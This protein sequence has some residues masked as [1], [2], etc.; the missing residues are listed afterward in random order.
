MNMTELKDLVPL[1][2]GVKTA[3]AERFNKTDQKLTGM[4][5]ELLELQQKAAG[6]SSY[7]GGGDF[8]GRNDGAIKQLFDAE[9]EG[10]RRDR[11]KTVAF[12]LPK[13]F[14][15]KTAII[16]ATGQNQPLVVAQRAPMVQPVQRRLSIRDLIPTFRTPSNLIEFTRE[17]AFTNNAAIVYASPNYENVTKPESAVTFSLATA[18]VQTLAHW[19][20]ASRQVLADSEMLLSYLDQRLTHKL[21][22]IEEDEILNGDGSAGHFSGLMSQATAYA[23]SGAV[24]SDTQVDSLR[25]AIT[26]LETADHQ[27]TG[28]VLNPIDW[29]KIALIKDTQG[30]YVFG[31]P[32]TA[33]QP[34]IHGVP[35]IVSNSIAA[36]RFLVGDFGQAAALWDREE[37]MMRVA[38]QHSDFFVKNMVA[39]LV[40]ERLALT[41]FKPAALVRGN[42]N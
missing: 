32:K 11:I 10:V 17:T 42:F 37:V 27:A 8:S 26:Q 16:N 24:S 21:K 23:G 34:A 29:M 30:R 2:E 15:A 31:D 33:A 7:H 13:D 18:A 36:T 9:L 22:L 20:P 14:L 19:I 25:R 6:A 35:V 41:V 38:E 1:I 5:A 3:A 40:E 12:E 4:S 28:I 39:L